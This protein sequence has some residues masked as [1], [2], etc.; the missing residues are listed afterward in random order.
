[1]W[2]KNKQK[3]G[4]EICSKRQI[5]KFCPAMP[6]RAPRVEGYAGIL[7]LHHESNCRPWG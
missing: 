7:K 3:I 1:M 4:K 5:P 6:M 2:R